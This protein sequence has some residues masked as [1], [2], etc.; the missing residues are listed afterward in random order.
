VRTRTSLI[1]N[2][3]GWMRAQGIKLQ[4]TPPWFARRLRA[5]CETLPEWI[6]RSLAVLDVVNAQIAE[7]DKELMSHASSDELCQR[8]MTVPGVGPVTAIRFAAVVDDVSRFADAH[9]LQAYVGLVPGVWQSSD[10]ERSL[11]ITKAGS[12]ELRRTLIQAAWSTRRVRHPMVD[13]AREVE[14]RRGKFVAT[15]ALARK[16][17]GILYAIWRDGSVYNPLR[18]NRMPSAA[19][20][21]KGKR[22]SAVASRPLTPS[23]PTADGS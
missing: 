22:P 11:G 3:R 17:V 9:A 13:W 20:G 21:V 6:N 2:T 8:L 1:N 19:G 5:K 16:L 14:K 15:V 18:T 23:S 12:P 7:A 4:C 10:R